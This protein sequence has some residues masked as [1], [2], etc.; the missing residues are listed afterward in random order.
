MR[1]A[2][3][4]PA[5]PATSAAVMERRG[6]VALKR[7]LWL[8]H[9]VLIAVGVYIG[10]DL[11][12]AI[13][14]SRLEVKSRV[15]SVSPSMVAHTPE[16]RAFQQY[17]VI[18]ERNLFGAR[19]RAAAPPPRPAPPA[20]PQP[21]PAPNLKLVGTVVGTNEHTYAVIEDVGAKR[22]ELYRLGD[23]IQEAKVVEIARNRVVLD[24]RGRR[25]E[26]LSFE[27]ADPQPAVSDPVTRL[28][29]PPRRPLPAQEPRETEPAQEPAPENDNDMEVEIERVSENMWRL[30][31]DD[32]VE[33]LDNL[34]QLMTDARLTPHFK[35]GQA[36]GFMITNLPR[37]SLL[38]RLGLRNGD[39]MK[40]VNGQRFGSLEE[41]LQ[42]Y[43]QLQSEPMLQIEI[44]RGNRA[45]TLNYEIR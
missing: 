4:M 41:V 36:D 31:R 44:E 7:Y 12:W 3:Q 37:D 6:M 2:M 16:K 39:I 19:G 40:G 28:A 14:A 20:A 34:G 29:S 13:M 22:Q 24:N 38:A 8:V 25:Q 45:E 11:F 9:L 27:K 18:Q 42:I 23:L 10:A 32:L 30:S 43:Q 15:P 5:L 17:A 35:A 1:P 33:Q 21:K 26:L